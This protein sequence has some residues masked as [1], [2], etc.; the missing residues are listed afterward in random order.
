MSTISLR[1][2]DSLHDAVR[3][4]VREAMVKVRVS[5][6]GGQVQAV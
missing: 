1:I 2:P 6:E 3:E 4:L 5:L